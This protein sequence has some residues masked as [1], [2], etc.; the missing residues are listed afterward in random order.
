[1]HCY[2]TVLHNSSPV[3]KMSNLYEYK[4]SVIN[5]N[6]AVTEDAGIDNKKFET[7]DDWYKV[8][9]DYEFQ[10]RCPIIL[11]NS[12]RN[13][14]F[15]FACH[16]KNCQFKILLSYCGNNRDALINNI[17]LHDID[18][19]DN[20]VALSQSKLSS[21]NAAADTSTNNDVDDSNVDTELRTKKY[22][23]DAVDDDDDVTAAIVAA[24]AAVNN[25]NNNDEDDDGGRGVKSEGVS[26]SKSKSSDDNSN[27]GGLVIDDY[28][29]S[30]NNN[31]GKNELRGPFMVTK[32]DPYHNHPLESNLSLQKFV[33]TK[34]PKILQNELNFDQKLEELCNEE[35]NT[36]SKFKVAQFVEDSDLLPVLKKNFKLSDDDIDKTF[37]GQI[38]R[39]VTT[40]KARFVLK[41]KKNGEYHTAT[42][43]AVGV[44]GSSNATKNTA[45]S[46]S[47][48]RNHTSSMVRSS[49]VNSTR[50][51]MLPIGNNA[52][53]HGEDEENNVYS[54]ADEDGN[55]ASMDDETR[56]RTA[57][58]E[59]QDVVYA[60]NAMVNEE[61]SIK[62]MKNNKRLLNDNEDNEDSNVHPDLEEEDIQRKRSRID[63]NNES[64]SIKL[65]ALDETLMALED[66]GDDKLPHEVAEQLRLLSSHFKDELVQQHNHNELSNKKEDIPDENIQP[67]LRGQ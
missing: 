28:D 34:I 41:K 42:G 18:D 43:N 5:K 66:A 48:A 26:E 49:D 12:H 19:I 60:A 44:N 7:L 36:I 29:H 32:I 2:T 17:N 51:E 27:E 30:Q 9:Q 57:L 21:N 50:N 33:L 10:A 13:K 46:V 20:H 53:A 64:A 4:H 40:Y 16:L 62:A 24:V 45:T 55:L 58:K 37:K 14:H 8:I 25:N 31:G 59:A 47:S 67:E 56:L 23:A 61:N 39:R 6:L 65:N 52:H 22:D 3:A 1:M 38:A 54:N 11:K 35:E 15:T 63:N